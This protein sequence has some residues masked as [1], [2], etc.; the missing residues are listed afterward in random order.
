MKSFQGGRD[1]LLPICNFIRENGKVLRISL[2]KS[3]PITG[4]SKYRVLLPHY[5]AHWH[6]TNGIESEWDCQDLNLGSRL[7]HQC[8]NRW[9]PPCNSWLWTRPPRSR[10]EPGPLGWHTNALADGFLLVIADSE[11]DREDSNLGRVENCASWFLNQPH[12]EA[13]GKNNSQ[14]VFPRGFLKR[15][16]GAC[17]YSHVWT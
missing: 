5:V 3:M 15:A 12:C 11:L 9:V 8:S 2:A 14:C 4:C 13:K 16:C 1:L 17:D 6:I 7:A 10:Y